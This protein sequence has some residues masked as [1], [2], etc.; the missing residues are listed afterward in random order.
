MTSSLYETHLQGIMVA[1]LMNTSPAGNH[2]SVIDEYHYHDSLQ[3]H[4]LEK[5]AICSVI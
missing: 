4:L 1:K 3:A 2:G 5:L